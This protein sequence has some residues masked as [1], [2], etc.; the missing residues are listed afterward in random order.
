MVEIFRTNVRGV[1]KANSI[2]EELF[3]QFPSYHFNFDLSDCDR[4]LRVE[5]RNGSIDA[6]A[7]IEAATKCSLEI[8]LI[9]E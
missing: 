4:I 7:V 2:I 8:S 5:S 6:A 1:S 3:E 9:P